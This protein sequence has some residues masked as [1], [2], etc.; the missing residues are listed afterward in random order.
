MEIS[1]I[2]GNGN[3]EKTPYISG[4]ETFFI[5]WK[6]LT[7]KKSFIFPKPY[8]RNRKKFLIFLGTEHFEP[9]KKNKKTLLKDFL[10]FLTFHTLHFL[11]FIRLTTFFCPQ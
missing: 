7:L 8:F 2:L 6:T 3:P 5:F 4:S 11:H 1:Y 10:R 9:E